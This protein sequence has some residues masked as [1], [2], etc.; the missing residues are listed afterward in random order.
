ME[1]RSSSEGVS[2]PSN[3]FGKPPRPPSCFVTSPPA[4]Q[5]DDF[6]NFTS[7]A[8]INDFNR[9]HDADYSKPIV[10]DIRDVTPPIPSLSPRFSG[11]S[12]M[13]SNEFPYSI[14]SSFNDHQ[15]SRQSSFA[16]AT[17]TFASSIDDRLSPQPSFTASIASS[18]TAASI[19]QSQRSSDS[20]FA[21]FTSGGHSRSSSL[22]PKETLQL[23]VDANHPPRSRRLE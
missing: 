4:T 8:L 22:I 1:W 5:A 14:S 12:T 19:S 13:D 18:A 9:M 16:A 7:D 10:D 20:G 21:S 11:A 3:D 6:V 2:H 23:L 17:T 15:S